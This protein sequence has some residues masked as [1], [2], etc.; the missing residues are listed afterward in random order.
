MKTSA[1][2]A[3]MMPRLV[4]RPFQI[5]LLLIVGLAGVQGSSLAS[6]AVTT[7]TSPWAGGTIPRGNTVVLANGASLTGPVVALGTLTFSGTGP[8]NAG[9][10]ITGSGTVAVVGGGTVSFTGENAPSTIRLDFTT[11]V[12]SGVLNAGVNG[13][14]DLSI[15]ENDRGVLAISGGMVRD[16]FGFVGQ[17]GAVGVANVSS[18]TWTNTGDLFVG[19][20]YGTGLLSLS[21]GQVTNNSTYLGYSGGSGTA[22][23]SGGEWSS[24]A[25]LEIGD[26]GQGAMYLSGGRVSNATA[27]L[28]TDAGGTGLALIQGG[29]W[30]T[31]GTMT[32]GGNGTASVAVAGGQIETRATA[33]N[34]GSASVT[35]G[36]W[37]TSEQFSM[38]ASAGTSQL[39]VAGGRLVAGTSSVGQEVGSS[40]SATISDGVW[41][42][43]QSLTIGER[44]L[45]TVRVLGGALSSQV[46]VLGGLGGGKGVG[47]L[48]QSGGSSWSG[49]FTIG[50]SGTG[51]FRLSGGNAAVNHMSTL[52]GNLGATGSAILTGGTWSSY[53]IRIGQSG[54][55]HVELSGGALSAV[56]GGVTIG[57]QS[58]G[59][60]DLTMMSGSISANSMT[61]SNYGTGVFQMLGGTASM[62]DASIG[63]GSG[64]SGTVVIRGGTWKPNY[65][66]VG[67]SGQGVLNI[68]GGSVTSDNTAIGINGGGFGTATLTE[69]SWVAGNLVV[70]AAG[71]GRLSQSGGTLTSS[72][73][74]LASSFYSGGTEVSVSG[75]SWSNSGSL[76][77]GH[78]GTASLVLSGGTMSSSGAVL[79]SEFNLNYSASGTSV[80][81]GGQWINTGE[82]TVGK[83]N[84]VLTCT[85]GLTAT[86]SMRIGA[87][88]YGNYY[89]Y[90]YG[91]RS[92]TG[93]VTVTG[94]TTAVRDSLDV[95]TYLYG[96]YPQGS[97]TIADKGVVSVGGS[98]NVGNG[99]IALRPGGTLLVGTGSTAGYLNTPL[100]NDGHLV[101]STPSDISHGNSLSGSGAFTK[102]GA[103]GLTFNTA[104]TCTGTTTVE[105]GWLRITTG[106]FASPAIVKAGCSLQIDG[107]VA[108]RSPSITL[109]GGTLSCPSIAVSKVAGIGLLDVQSGQVAVNAALS[110]ADSGTVR[111]SNVTPS[112]MAVQTLAIS[113]TT[114]G[115]VD[116]GRGRVTIAA[117]GISAADLRSNL[118][119]GR[120]DGSWSGTSGIMSSAVDPFAGR[121]VGYR[122]LANSSA[123]VAF[124]AFGDCTLDGQVNSADVSLIINAGL[125][126]KG[127]TSAVWSQGDFNYDGFVDALDVTLFFSAG[128]FGTGPYNTVA[129]ANSLPF[130]PTSSVVAVPEPTMP[131]WLAVSASAAAGAWW[132]SR[133]RDRFRSR[134][135]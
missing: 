26:D 38:G 25:K 32:I 23:I 42:S 120:L 71:F 69:G 5:A 30:A 119:A 102:R 110:I 57:D 11:S 48:I 34:S 8:M 121:A 54:T 9:Q 28:G 66:Y 19:G 58:S 92:G 123:T 114:G 27:S 12:Q 106:S 88:A 112:S 24:A 107:G 83:T 3:C 39:S 117:G 22:S 72:G 79:G 104:L 29:T 46:L 64:G 108:V 77:V 73:V 49:G 124:A 56:S 127:G 129:S 31:S 67:Q 44:G 36:T 65:V 45:G 103:G 59:C 55:G 7:I 14:L 33:L 60:G 91:Y 63:A 128:V 18:G 2:A 13:G 122:V 41:E 133:R 74:S 113:A 1:L 68:A 75:G 105:G 50:G 4:A 16:R 70:G 97:L 80:V 95:G 40:N 135:G 131:A 20:D 116:I 134:I 98:V 89:W 10:A 6:A 15:G 21:G 35:S 126:D 96:Y 90:Y 53:G 132:I 99:T 101:L 93:S 109:L 47:E 52:G 86:D 78:S 81:S 82:M 111:L 51:V 61:V 76:I 100:V 87:I 62:A 17:F 94:G 115:C 37:N 118:L 125:Y 130:S 84:G 43:A 85:G